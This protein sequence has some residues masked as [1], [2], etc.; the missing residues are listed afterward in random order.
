MSWEYTKRKAKCV[1]CGHEGFCIEGSDD[2]MRSSTR[3]EGFKEE[4]PSSTRVRDR[5]RV[6]GH[7]RGV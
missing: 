6:L 5:R 3:W 4:R 1:K 7:E 2:W